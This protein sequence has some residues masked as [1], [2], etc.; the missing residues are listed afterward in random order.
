MQE[1]TATPINAERY[2]E[3]LGWL[4]KNGTISNAEADDGCDS[5]LITWHPGLEYVAIN[6][7]DMID[8]AHIVALGNYLSQFVKE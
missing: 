3:E 7:E 4:Q 8:I 6:D 1:M 2:L 5:L